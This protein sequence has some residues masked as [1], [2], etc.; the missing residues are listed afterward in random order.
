MIATSSQGMFVDNCAART[1]GSSTHAA[2]LLFTSK[3]AGSSTSHFVDIPDVEPLQN[4][5]GLRSLNGISR[6]RRFRSNGSNPSR[7]MKWK[8]GASTTDSSVKQFALIECARMKTFKDFSSR[9]SFLGRD[10]SSS[11]THRSRIATPLRSPRFFR[12]SEATS[13]RNRRAL[14]K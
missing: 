11:I 5:S 2:T 14:L 1:R 3:R 9:C 7:L 12:C 10:A 8:F 13:R 4:T 6:S